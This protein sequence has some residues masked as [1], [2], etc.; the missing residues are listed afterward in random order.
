MEAD[1]NLIIPSHLPGRKNHFSSRQ[2][3]CN[4][5]APGQYRQWT[6]AI[7]LSHTSLQALTLSLQ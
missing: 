1:P 5:V 6:Q 2:C 3:G 4:T 7:Q